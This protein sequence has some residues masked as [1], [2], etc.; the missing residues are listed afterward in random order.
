MSMNSF[1]VP[2]ME[3]SPFSLANTSA[4]KSSGSTKDFEE[5]RQTG[6]VF[7][8]LDLR[9]GHSALVAGDR[10]DDGDILHCRLRE[11]DMEDRQD[12]KRQQDTAHARALGMTETLPAVGEVRRA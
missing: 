4:S 1:S 6:V 9:V 2:L 3:K 8:E 5:R 7:V 12:E 11:E 10:A